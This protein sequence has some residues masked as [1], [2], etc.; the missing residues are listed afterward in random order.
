[1][2]FLDGVYV[3]DGFADLKRAFD[4]TNP[5][6]REELSSCDGDC[7]EVFFDRIDDIGMERKVFLLCLPALMK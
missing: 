1:M 7:L 6:G 5:P 3:I 4:A 2:L